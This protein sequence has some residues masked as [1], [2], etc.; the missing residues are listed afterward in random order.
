MNAWTWGE[1]GF[2]VNCLAS[3]DFRDTFRLI[4][5]EM[6]GRM[7]AA[8][9]YLITKPYRNLHNTVIASIPSTKFSYVT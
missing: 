5:P 6:Y 1:S 9:Q 8:E 3:H 4:G 7:L 2:N